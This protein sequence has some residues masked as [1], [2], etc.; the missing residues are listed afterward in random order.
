MF[1]RTAR[2]YN[3]TFTIRFLWQLGDKRTALDDD[4]TL[5]G[6]EN[7]YDTER[8]IDVGNYS[9]GSI[10]EKNVSIEDEL[11]F[12]INRVSVSGGKGAEITLCKERIT[13]ELSDMDKVSQQSII[14]YCFIQSGSHKSR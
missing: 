1:P 9:R 2:N 14:V 5:R 8:D 4:D 10:R 11:P 7:S 6:V 13:A 3:N 12:E